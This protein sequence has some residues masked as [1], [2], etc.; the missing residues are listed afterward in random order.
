MRHRPYPN[1]LLAL[2]L[3]CTAVACSSPGSSAKSE[4]ESNGT[5]RDAESSATQGQS[6]EPAQAEPDGSLDAPM[7]PSD[8]GMPP[9]DA[10][11]Q[12]T[13]PIPDSWTP[14]NASC[15]ALGTSC[16]D[17][18]TCGDDTCHPRT[19]PNGAR[20]SGTCLPYAAERCSPNGCN[21]AR[22]YCIEGQCMTLSEAS[23][24]CTTEHALK[25]VR[26]CDAGPLAAMNTSPLARG[27][28]C[29]ETFRACADGLNCL[30][31]GGGIPRCYQGCAPT[32]PCPDNGCCL[33]NGLCG[34][35]K[36][37]E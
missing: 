27:E 2:V 16:D 11:Q 9:A 32:I 26:H 33:S 36:E 18:S 29:G 25:T 10:G 8:A 23:C 24:S 14:H 13:G 17:S 34:F 1:A 15:G 3:A 6:M 5:S 4:G 20:V 22:P 7:L 31:V 28:P 21:P 19:G 35:G 12:G 30:R 37:C